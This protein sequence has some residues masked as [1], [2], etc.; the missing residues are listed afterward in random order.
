MGLFLLY[1]FVDGS[2]RIMIGPKG[3]GDCYEHLLVEPLQGR[4]G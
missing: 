3:Q 2:R 4:K 1:I